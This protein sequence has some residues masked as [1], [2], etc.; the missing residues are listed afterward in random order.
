MPD[1]EA[2]SPLWEWGEPRGGTT[3]AARHCR[4]RPHGCALAAATTAPGAQRAR[5]LR[6]YP[7]PCKDLD[8]SLQHQRGVQFQ[9][10][11]AAASWP[12]SYQ[13]SKHGQSR[14]AALQCACTWHALMQWG[15]P[16][17]CCRCIRC[18]ATRR[19][20]GLEEVGEPLLQLQQ[21]GTTA[22]CNTPAGHGVANTMLLRPLP[23]KASDTSE[24]LKAQWA[25]AGGDRSLAA[26]LPACCCSDCPHVLEGAGRRCFPG[27]RA[28]TWHNPCS[29]QAPVNA[30][31]P[32]HS[33]LAAGLPTLK[34]SKTTCSSQ[35]QR[36]GR[37]PGTL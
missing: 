24:E 12:D 32:A 29:P 22:C 31:H 30:S 16:P 37:Y 18:S 27:A 8:Q 34:P 11:L 15:P 23:R 20:H 36:M 2:N 9:P 25:Q 26:W 28:S 14:V 7:G 6:S 4:T 19:K 17:D 5:K 13:A 1:T 3:G 35:Q 10:P 21:R 33:L